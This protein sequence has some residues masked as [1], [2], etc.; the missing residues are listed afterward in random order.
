VGEAHI[1]KA[2]AEVEKGAEDS[3][4]VASVVGAFMR[5]QPMIGHYVQAHTSEVTLEGMVLVLLHASV[6]VRAVEI[7]GGRRLKVVQARDLDRATGR[8]DVADLK[9][10]EPELVTYLEANVSAED[11]TLGGKRRAVALGLLRVILRAIIDVA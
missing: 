11:P 8:S 10:E 3:Q 1:G 6:L 5:K 4:H 2:V 9:A 7:A